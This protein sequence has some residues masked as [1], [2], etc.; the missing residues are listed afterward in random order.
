MSEPLEL[1]RREINSLT[2]FISLMDQK[3]ASV[4]RG[5]KRAEAS[6]RNDLFMRAHRQ[7]L[8]FLQAWE[9]R[10]PQELLPR[11]AALMEPVLGYL[12]HQLDEAD[13]ICPSCGYE[14]KDESLG[15][16]HHEDCSLQSAITGLRGLIN[17]P[18]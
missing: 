18:N 10:R 8:A 14:V 6:K 17:A 1:C 5:L 2:A 4:H 12:Q 11:G 9:L 16:R 7:F 13:G 3:A 15:R